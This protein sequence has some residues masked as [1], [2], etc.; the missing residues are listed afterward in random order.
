MFES[1]I[2]PLITKYLGWLIE[3]LN[4]DSLQLGLFGGDVVLNDL[5]VKVRL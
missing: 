4:E 1:F 3:D 5:R 2:A